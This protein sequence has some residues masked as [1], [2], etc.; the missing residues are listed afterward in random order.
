[1]AAAASGAK[2]DEQMKLVAVIVIFGIVIWFNWGKIFK[3]ST[4]SQ[5]TSRPGAPGAPG[6]PGA[7][8]GGGA[9]PDAAS[10]APTVTPDQIPRIKAAYSHLLQ[11]KMNTTQAVEAI[12]QSGTAP[13]NEVLLKFI[14]TSERGVT[15]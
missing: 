1:M 14:E 12:R 13:E 6:V 10:S 3:S 7:P 8:A 2:K 15:K 9:A 4:K 11:S 5:N